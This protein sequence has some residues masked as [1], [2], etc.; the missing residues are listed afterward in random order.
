M[1]VSVLGIN[2]DLFAGLIGDDGDDNAK[3]IGEILLKLSGLMVLEEGHIA[4]N[5]QS[6]LWQALRKVET[7]KRILFSETLF[8]TNIKEFYNT[9]S[10]VYAK[11]GADPQQKWVYISS[12]IDK[13]ARAL[14]ELRD[15]TSP[16]VHACS[17][18]VKKVSLTE[19]DKWW[20]TPTIPS[21]SFKE[22]SLL[23]KLWKVY[24][25]FLGLLIPSHD[26]DT[27]SS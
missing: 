11:F 5:E 20:K 9:L 19:L 18:D 7:E 24:Y 26:E 4:R 3:E 23:F 22:K 25:D 27:R 12:S 10:I 2:Y 15:I 17:Q 6:L 13:N 8:Q 16:I 21:S 1:K 14:E